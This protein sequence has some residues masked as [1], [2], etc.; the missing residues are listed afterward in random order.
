[1]VLQ[2]FATPAI[3]SD[4][5]TAIVDW[6]DIVD[7]NGSGRFVTI[8]NNSE[9][10]LILSSKAEDFA[11]LTCK[12]RATCGAKRT[13]FDAFANSKFGLRIGCALVVQGF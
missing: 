9:A 3:I 5:L 7:V 10:A 2:A 4:Q 1:M 13:H 11:G 12:S 6:L 8:E